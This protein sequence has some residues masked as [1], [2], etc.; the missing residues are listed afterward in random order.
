RIGEIVRQRGSADL[1]I[2]RRGRAEI[3]NLADYIGGQERERYAREALR[4]LLAQHPDIVCGRLV[5]FVQLDL[6]VAVLGAERA[7]G[8]VGHVDAAAGQA[9]IVDH[10][11]EIFRRNEP[12]DRLL[13]LGELLRGFLDPRAD[14]R[15]RV[16]QDLP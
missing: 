13:D 7:A 15:A 4:Q 10:G 16:H 14:V 11:P 8:V 6:N 12:A 2:N 1:Q 5:V 3:E 9:D